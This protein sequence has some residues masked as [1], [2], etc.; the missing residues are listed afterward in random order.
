MSGSAYSLVSLYVCLSCVISLS[1]LPSRN[2]TLSCVSTKPFIFTSNMRITFMS[3]T[4]AP[5]FGVEGGPG[6]RDIS[7]GSSAVSAFLNF[8]AP[9]VRRNVLFRC[10]GQKVVVEKFY[11]LL[12]LIL[13]LRYVRPVYFVHKQNSV[14]NL[15]V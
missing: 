4:W 8:T 14:A 7:P 6:E 10:T 13:F 3:S 2:F 5:C 1:C 12:C 9:F 11:A 15:M